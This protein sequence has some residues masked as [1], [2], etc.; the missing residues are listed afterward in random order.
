MSSPLGNT[1][2]HLKKP[3]YYLNALMIMVNHREEIKRGDL[4]LFN[5]TLT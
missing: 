1:T 2:P 3:I 4:E 5:K